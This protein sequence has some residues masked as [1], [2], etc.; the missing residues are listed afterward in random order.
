[1][2]CKWEDL[3]DELKTEEV[4]PYYDR[5]MKLFPDVFA[6]A[7]AEDEILLKAWE[8]LGYYN[9]VRNL[10]KAAIEICEKYGGNIPDNYEEIIKKNM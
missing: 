6:L 1:M 3:P 8:G 7:D 10:K 4:K 9:R 5:F 2:L